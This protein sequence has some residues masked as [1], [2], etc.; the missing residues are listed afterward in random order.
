[1]LPRL[2][3]FQLKDVGQPR[4]ETGRCPRARLGKFMKWDPPNCETVLLGPPLFLRNGR[5]VQFPTR[6]SLAI[7]IFL[8]AQPGVA[9]E[10][11]RL[12]GLLW[13]DF[14]GEAARVSLRKALSLIG[15]NDD[16]ASFIVRDRGAVRCAVD[17]ARTDL[18]IFIDRISQRTEEGYREAVKLWRGEPLEGAEIGE[19]AF[20]DWVREFRTTTTAQ[21][22]R[23]LNTQLAREGSEPVP[24]TTQIALCELIVHIDP[25]EIAASER[26]VRL[27]ID[28]GDPA[29]AVRRLRVLKAALD[30]L[31]LP[32]PTPLLMLEKTLRSAAL[33]EAPADLAPAPYH[34]IPTVV[35]QR[36][37]GLPAT[38]DVFSFAHSEVMSQLTRFRSLRCFEPDF[39]GLAVA[40]AETGA[41]A[42]LVTRVDGGP[43]HDYR[44]LLWNEPNA[45]ALYLRCV[46]MH[47]LATVSCVR[48]GYDELADR[49][50]A[51]RLI[52][53]AVNAIEL[54]ILN[55]ET[56]NANTPFA[57]WL[58][59]Y[60]EM[61][62]FNARSDELAHEILTSL[63]NDPH[64]SRLSL[65][66]SSLTAI[67]VKRTMYYPGPQ[68]SETERRHARTR[69]QMALGIDA[70]EPF[71]HIIAGW[72]AIQ[73]RR[74]E[75]ARG[76]F[77]DA[78][79]LNRYSSRTLISA[80]E[81][82][83]FCGDL[84]EAKRLADRAMALSGRTAPAYFHAYLAT[85]A[86]L[87][88][89]LDECTRRL[90]RS[91]QNGHTLLLAI[92]A[93][94]ERNE[95]AAALGARVRFEEELRSM[96]PVGGV[97]RD[98]LSQWMITA[99]MTRDEGARRRMFGALERAGLP[100][101][102]DYA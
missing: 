71:N 88:G 5:S 53:G 92:A 7:C 61:Q 32:L 51:D 82:L 41:N 37:Q 10:R 68:A 84:D 20:D 36:P 44:L 96:E 52:A 81:A 14:E 21:I 28:I 95:R 6:K 11:P 1:M 56:P 49:N 27:F 3:L 93:Y 35:L 58:V 31:D 12:C 45:G 65:V 77:E 13:G 8:A 60:Q 17:P 89:D 43:Q 94:E 57:R 99:N 48:L 72:H 24:L 76:N 74:Y 16:T 39:E 55:D 67:H 75:S 80:A 64:G 26:L 59:A 100:V 23:H 69:S 46:N 15:T 85:I 22:L 33:G 91:P 42:P 78:L 97:D 70:Q 87:D 83:A 101:G 38:P 29:A 19:P 30:D 66:H 98:A 4:E 63:A 79:A 54:D 90:H 40:M 102:L 18:S 62:K 9:V 47:R 73:E 34:G 86:Y 25:T 50:H 2:E